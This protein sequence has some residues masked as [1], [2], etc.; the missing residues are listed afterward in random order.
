MVRRAVGGSEGWWGAA[1]TRGQTAGGAVGESG[2]RPRSPA[3]HT[4]PPPR[5]HPLP[6]ISPPP[7]L[8][9]IGKASQDARYDMIGLR[10]RVGHAGTSV[11]A[12]A[13]MEP[14]EL[15]VTLHEVYADMGEKGGE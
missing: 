15:D 8:L 4:F 3:Q 12:A 9:S 11:E 7:S 6:H 1:H 14:E 10:G 13:E 2:A 5:S